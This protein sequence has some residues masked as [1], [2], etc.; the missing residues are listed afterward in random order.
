MNRILKQAQLN[1]VLIHL[2]FLYYT[3]EHDFGT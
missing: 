3:R 1:T 2:I